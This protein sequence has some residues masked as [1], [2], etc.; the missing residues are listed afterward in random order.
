MFVV[1]LSDSPSLPPVLS[2][3]HRGDAPL[4]EGYQHQLAYDSLAE[5]VEEF[6]W[7]ASK[8]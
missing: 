6:E 3:P 7:F 1:A 2:G 8:P 4:P 5:A